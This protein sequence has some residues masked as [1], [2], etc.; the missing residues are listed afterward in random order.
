MSASL[1]KAARGGLIWPILGALLSVALVFTLASCRHEAS[2]PLEMSWNRAD[3]HYGPNFIHLESPCLSNPEPGCFCSLDFKTTTSKEFADYVESFGS[4]K[5]RVKFHV[6]YNRNHQVI[7]AILEGVAEWPEERFHIN[8]RSLSTG[9]RMLPNKRT[10]GGHINNPA[11][12]FPES[13]K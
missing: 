1:E 2:V 9:F 8:E 6:D 5:V 12:C 13:A 11:D 4:N 10:G 3:N 7:G